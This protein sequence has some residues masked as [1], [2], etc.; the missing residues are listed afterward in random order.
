ME[1]HSSTLIVEFRYVNALPLFTLSLCYY[2]NA[3]FVILF[4]N[5]TILNWQTKKHLFSAA[6]NAILKLIAILLIT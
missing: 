4:S 5:R 6:S 2:L 1:V 3:R